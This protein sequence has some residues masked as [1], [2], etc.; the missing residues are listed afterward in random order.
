MDKKILA[1][2]A[3]IS[4]ECA[5][6]SVAVMKEARERAY[7]AGGAGLVEAE[8]GGWDA[9]CVLVLGV[10]RSY[11]T[12]F[13]ADDDSEEAVA[14]RRVLEGVEASLEL[15]NAMRQACPDCGTKHGGE[16]TH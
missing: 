5:Q 16:V 3:R 1:E 7:D 2:V 9:A 10:L 13:D 14:V 4:S 15:A 8:N 12:I 6:Q 11:V